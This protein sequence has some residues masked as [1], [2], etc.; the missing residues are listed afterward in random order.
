MYPLLFFST[1]PI[2][3]L[4]YY[5]ILYS[6]LFINENVTSAEEV[7]DDLSIDG[8]YI[9]K[10]SVTGKYSSEWS[11]LETPENIQ[12]QKEVQNYYSQEQQLKTTSSTQQTIEQL[13]YEIELNKRMSY[14]I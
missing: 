4:Y 2:N 6:F 5:K 8:E 14:G 3:I 12:L 1:F 9:T 11:H 7:T 10:D 13:N